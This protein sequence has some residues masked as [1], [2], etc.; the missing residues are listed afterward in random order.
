MTQ[1]TNVLLQVENLKKH[2]PVNRGWF[3]RGQARFLRAVDGLSIHV[4]PRETLGLVGE[5]GCGKTTTGR[6]IMGLEPATDGQ[7]FLGDS[8]DLCSLSGKEWMPYRRRIQMI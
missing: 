5:S 1:T 3:Q 8:D 4:K 7:V 2:Y 6:V